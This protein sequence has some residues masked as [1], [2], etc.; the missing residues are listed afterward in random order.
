MKNLI[1]VLLP[2][3]IMTDLQIYYTYAYPFCYIVM[4]SAPSPFLSLIPGPCYVS[5]ITPKLIIHCPNLEPYQGTNIKSFIFHISKYQVSTCAHYVNIRVTW[6][7]L[8][9]QVNCKP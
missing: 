6:K 2:W 5:Q 3:K 8:I 7:T 9:V 1:V 4:L